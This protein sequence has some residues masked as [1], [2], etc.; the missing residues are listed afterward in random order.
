[1]AIFFLLISYHHLVNSILSYYLLSFVILLHYKVN[2][3]RTR[4]LSG[5]FSYILST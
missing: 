2:S 4:T 5:V 3:V 1:M